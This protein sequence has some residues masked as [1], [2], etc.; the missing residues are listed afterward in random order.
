MH[1][2]I[3]PI[4]A[5][6]G[7]LSS[8][9]RTQD[10]Q[11]SQYGT[12][13]LPRK[14]YSNAVGCR[15]FIFFSICR[16]IRYV[17]LSSLRGEPM[18]T[19]MRSC[20]VTAVHSAGQRGYWAHSDLAIRIS[21][22]AEFFLPYCLADLASAT[23]PLPAI[24]RR[25]TWSPRG[26]YTATSPRRP[27]PALAGKRLRGLAKTGDAVRRCRSPRR[28]VA[29]LGQ[30]ETAGSLVRRENLPNRAEHPTPPFFRLFLLSSAG[31]DH[32]GK[33]TQIGYGGL[34]HPRVHCKT[35]MVLNLTRWVFGP[36]RA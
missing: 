5:N 29:R 13:S 21:N 36:R 12:C 17:Q 27:P 20:P 4:V 15:S 1:A 22:Q 9:T 30:S 24:R 34:Q 10:R 8:P 7:Q 23:R 32:P 35:G 3:G 18:T 2:A 16:M 14:T 6:S 19:S 31:Q 25:V 26:E 28:C 11:P 33:F